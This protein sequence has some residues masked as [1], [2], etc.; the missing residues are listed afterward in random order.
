MQKT[1]H[2]QSLSI[3][4]LTFQLETSQQLPTELLPSF[5]NSLH[6]HFHCFSLFSILSSSS[7]FLCFFSKENKKNDY[8]LITES[9]L[10]TML[11]H[12]KWC[13]LVINGILKDKWLS[14]H[15][16]GGRSECLARASGRWNRI[17]PIL[18]HSML[19]L[20]ISLHSPPSPDLRPEGLFCLLPVRSANI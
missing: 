17:P 4:S 6:L 18:P 19:S 20:Q 10:N 9:M 13:H 11:S 2:V 14:Y 8:F 3:E 12:F 15:C 5:T 16:M 7:I 1:L